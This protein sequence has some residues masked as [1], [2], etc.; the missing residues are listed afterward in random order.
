MK[1][2]NVRLRI[3]YNIILPGS[4]F[5]EAIY[6]LYSIDA[7]IT[8]RQYKDWLSKLNPKELDPDLLETY[9]KI[10]GSKL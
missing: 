4:K 2:F 5:E 1:I 8:K 7:K 3:Y 10:T 9:E 6:Y